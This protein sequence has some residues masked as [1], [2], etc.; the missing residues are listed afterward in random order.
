[1]VGPLPPGRTAQQKPTLPPSPNKSVKPAKS[2]PTLYAADE[3]RASGKFYPYEVGNPYVHF[4]GMP[5]SLTDECVAEMTIALQ[6]AHPGLASRDVDSYVSV[7][8][9]A[10]LI[11]FCVEQRVKGR[12]DDIA[13][14]VREQARKHA[15]DGCN[16][17]TNTSEV[18]RLV[19]AVAALYE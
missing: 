8:L 6:R 9:D 19:R 7:C 4:K 2:E 10:R 16:R 13:T 1:M 12:T 5:T 17:N 11:G 15:K 18:E 3:V 14:K